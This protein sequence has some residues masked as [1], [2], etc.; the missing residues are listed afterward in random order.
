[1]KSTSAETPHPAAGLASEDLT[2]RSRFA[3]NVIFGWGGQFVRIIAGFL[4]PRM[5]GDRLGQTSLGIWDFSWSIV[6]YFALLQLGL[7]GSVN[8]YVARF[9]A[10]SDRVALTR[11]VST[12]DL[13]L[14]VA[15]ML[16]MLATVVTVVW[17]LPFFGSQLGNGLADTRWTLF[18]LG[19]DLAL[20][21]ATSLYVGVVVG[22]HRSDLHNVLL[23]VSNILAL[24][25][26][27][28]AVFLGGGLASI[29]A[30]QF[31][32]SASINLW[33]I[34]V[35]RRICPEL[36]VSWRA[37]EWATF[38]EQLAFSA[39][40]VIPYL[41][42][43]IFHQ[44]SSLLIA[45][46]LGPASLAVFSRPRSL[47][48]N[49]RV[50]AARFAMPL[51]P[52][53]SSL[54]A[55]AEQRVLRQTLLDSTSALSFV[56]LPMV[57]ALALFGDVIIRL[58][59]GPKFVHPWLFE[60]V[61]LGSLASLI[62]EPSWNILVGLNKHG[63]VSFAQLGG[64]TVSAILLYL[65]LSVFHGGLVASALAIAIPLTVVDGILT[66][67]LACRYLRINLSEFFLRAFARPA[68]YVVPFALC[69]LAARLLW[70][71]RPALAV[72][73]LAF[74][75]VALAIIYWRLV[76]SERVR[77]KMLRFCRLTPQTPKAAMPPA[78]DVISS[79]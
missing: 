22:C 76:L 51:V 15:G 1:M 50:L 79:K 20:A 62:Q 19:A 60:V 36:K 65:T 33:R 59:M 25:G 37:A 46:F 4:I 69:S 53:A 42:Q 14:K 71:N 24:L 55:R 47:M 75:V 9:R 6:G 27:L 58:W 61:A 77:L 63:R 67:W 12:A 28:V 35:A 2:G 32:S 17:V 23:S 11:S 29:A 52:T 3:R 54:Q 66:P 34:R 68:F 40:N 45:A 73:A 72:A 39:K 7:S 18:F 26:M 10:V 8:R 41:A 30:A 64:A 56:V 48:N 49:V 31:L 38:V 16:I 74:G 21:A 5:I 44:T 78:A 43:L 57:I 13:S 70:P